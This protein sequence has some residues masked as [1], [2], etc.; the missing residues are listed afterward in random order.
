MR[1]RERRRQ[2]Q[3]RD[4]AHHERGRADVAEA[5]ERP[6]RLEH[7][8]ARHHGERERPQGADGDAVHGVSHGD[9]IRELGDTLEQQ[10]GNEPE[11]AESQRP[12]LGARQG[13][14]ELPR[15]DA[16]ERDQRRRDAERARA[17]GEPECVEETGAADERGQR[18]LV[19]A[20]D[21]IA[22]RDTPALEVTADRRRQRAPADD[23][24]EQREQIN[25]GEEG[26]PLHLGI[27]PERAGPPCRVNGEQRRDHGG[28]D[29]VLPA[30][31]A[32]HERRRGGG[33]QRRGEGE[34][35]NG[36]ER[37]RRERRRAP[38]D[39][40]GEQHPGHGVRPARDEKAGH[41][42][43]RIAEEHLVAVPGGRAQRRRER[44]RHEPQR[45]GERG[46]GRGD[47]E[48]DAV[49]FRPPAGGRRFVV[50]GHG[51]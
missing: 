10:A 45:H 23:Q 50:C 8:G 34:A 39:P 31:G 25:T 32:A 1:R 26:A 48:H 29:A 40:G 30:L 51:R 17:A 2:P 16:H 7:G 6:A 14:V 38:R 24:H 11:I 37:P 12:Q 21:E 49:G 43:D 18:Q 47:R 41:D 15:D 27:E 36:R 13:P 44:G 20:T 9:N 19:A 33:E 28:H 22:A 42:R 5:F 46:E 3:Q 35:E 4:G